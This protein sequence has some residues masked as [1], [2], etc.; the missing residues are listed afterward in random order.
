VGFYDRYLLP[1]LTHLTMRSALLEDYRRRTAS[2]AYGVVLELGF[3]SGLNLPFYQPARVQRLYALEP[4]EGM[5]TL[6]RPRIAQA[7][8]PVEVLQTGAEH[9][10]LPD[11]SVDTA[12]STWTLCTIPLVE[13]AV[14]EARRVLKPDGQFLFAEHGLSPEAP[15]ARWQHRLTPAWRRC[16]GGCHLNRKADELLH[17]AGFQLQGVEA[18]YLGPLKIATYMYQGRA[19]PQAPYEEKA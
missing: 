3:G 2:Q 12:L 9:I 1:R 19:R 15:V 18:G 8:F 13:Q 4:H 17:D 11:Q 14:R 7:P 6:A 16:A 10:P 5:L